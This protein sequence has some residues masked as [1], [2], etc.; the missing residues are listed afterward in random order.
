VVCPT[1]GA[2]V[3]DNEYLCPNCG[4]SL[5]TP[6][7]NTFYGYT[8]GGKKKK[9]R[10]VFWTVIIILV[11]FFGL[12]SVGLYYFGGDFFPFLGGKNSS[13][14]QGNAPSQN[15][16]EDDSL[17]IRITF[18]EGLRAEQ[19]A[20]LLEENRVC[21]AKEF[22]DATQTMD[23]A[24]YSFAADV[25]KNASERYYRL[26]GYLFPDTY[27]FYREEDPALVAEK[28]LLNFEERMTDDL[29]EKAAAREMTV[30][31]VVALASVITKEAGKQEEMPLVSS[32][33]HNRLTQEGRLE[34]D[35]TY[36][37]PYTAK[38]EIP[39][40]IRE[41]FESRYNTYKIQGL[42]PGAIC[43]PG[44]DAI[45][46][47]VEPETTQYYFFVYDINRNYY[48]AETWEEH[49]RNVEIINEIKANASNEAGQSGE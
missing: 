12:A 23:I 10:T 20:A 14:F 43:N 6:K 40:E 49:Q 21:S 22:I 29:R 19:I 8:P 4:V 46:A 9:N 7:V 34:S 30:D 31:E 3:P 18:R 35:P 41:T 2:Q 38:S 42:P 24:G 32:V 45:Q 37:Y 27:E 16:A 44:L 47:A 11:F 25:E 13:G 39:E 15:G 17:T 26:E 33:F 1:C 28:M 36:Y 48:F 5:T